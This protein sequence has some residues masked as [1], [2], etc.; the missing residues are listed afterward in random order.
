MT[1]NDTYTT[2]PALYNS[3]TQ[4]YQQSPF[5]SYQTPTEQE[6]KQ[7]N[8]QS[9]ELKSRQKYIDSSTLSILTTTDSNPFLQTELDTV[10]QFS[11]Y[12]NNLN[13]SSI[14]EDSV[15]EDAQQDDEEEY[16]ARKNPFLMDY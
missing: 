9:I 2:Q 10:E 8:D 11:K 13:L 7:D 15:T 3:S 14:E 16:D 6:Q 1:G 5:D 4:Y 12:A